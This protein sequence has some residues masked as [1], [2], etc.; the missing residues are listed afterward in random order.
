MTKR[1]ILLLGLWGLWGGCALF[2]DPRANCNHP[3]HEEYLRE[4]Q[5][6]R[7]AKQTRSYAKPGKGSRKV[8]KACP[9][10]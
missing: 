8:Q 9:N 10:P 5:A 7:L 6:S 3:K 2:R 1:V 4:Q